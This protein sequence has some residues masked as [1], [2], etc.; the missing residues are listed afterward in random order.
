MAYER[1]RSNSASQSDQEATEGDP[2]RFVVVPQDFT[3]DGEFTI[4]VDI[5]Y[6][7]EHAG[8]FIGSNG[9]A[10]CDTCSECAALR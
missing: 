5:G 1:G 3:K 6:P 9:V 7:I 8:D 4:G 2:N 10:C